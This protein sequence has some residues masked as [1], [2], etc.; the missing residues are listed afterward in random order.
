MS[1]LRLGRPLGQM[2]NSLAVLIYFNHSFIYFFTDNGMTLSL[3]VLLFLG[4]SIFG[5]QI[6]LK[7]IIFG[8]FEHDFIDF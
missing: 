1:D 5:L 2:R 6:F 3:V 4:F 8:D 7:L